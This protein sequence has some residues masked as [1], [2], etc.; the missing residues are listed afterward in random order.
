MSEAKKRHCRGCRNDFYNGREN[1]N[2]RDCWSLKTAKLV[3]RYEIHR[4]S[5]PT[6][7]GAFKK[8]R[9][10][11]CYHAPPMFYFEKLPNFVKPKDVRGAKR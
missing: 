9:V 2:G 8:V 6:V 11:D 4:D 1:I 5:L 3:T 7:P 10:H